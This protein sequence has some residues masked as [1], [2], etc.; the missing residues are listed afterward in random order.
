MPAPEPEDLRALGARLDE[1]R[2]REAARNVQQPPTSFGIAF[3]FSTE[4]VLA[5]AVGAA[6]GWGL[7]WLF[8]TRPVFIVVMSLFGAVAGIRNV[9]SAAREMNAQNPQRE[10]DEEK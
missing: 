1:V 5:L 2:R 4:L 10:D 6:M 3:R 7:D 9:M 8:G